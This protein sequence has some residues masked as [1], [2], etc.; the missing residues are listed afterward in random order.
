M[1]SPG[2]VTIVPV[3][4]IDGSTGIADGGRRTGCSSAWQIAPLLLIQLR[5]ETCSSTGRSRRDV[6]GIDGVRQLP[7]PGKRSCCVRSTTRIEFRAGRIGEVALDRASLGDA[8][9][10]RS[11]PRPART[12]YRGGGYRR[13]PASRN[14]CMPIL[15]IAFSI[16]RAGLLDRVVRPS[17]WSMICCSP[18]KND[19]DDGSRRASE[20]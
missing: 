16:R 5:Q 1:A 17:G 18:R 14:S 13:S 4:N 3:A 8:C 2:S 20:T 9:D 15:R 7:A 12:R 10:G 11:R 19:D 6:R